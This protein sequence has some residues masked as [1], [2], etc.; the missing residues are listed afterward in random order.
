M[1]AFLLLHGNGKRRHQKH[2][3]ESRQEISQQTARTFCEKTTR[4]RKGRECQVTKIYK[5]ENKNS[6]AQ[7]GVQ[8]AALFEEDICGQREER[9]RGEGRLP[10]ALGLINI[11]VGRCHL[12]Q[13]LLVSLSRRFIHVADV[14]QGQGS[15]HANRPYSGMH[16]W[17]RTGGPGAPL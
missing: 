1:F 3:R 2:F 4:E 6:N 11:G 10:T 13:Y 5:K 17:Q 12:S 14:P 15:A 7:R 16:K 9:K 8:S